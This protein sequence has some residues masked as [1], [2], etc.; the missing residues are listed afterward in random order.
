MHNG[1]IKVMDARTGRLKR[2]ETPRGKPMA[3]MEKDRLVLTEVGRQMGYKV[4]NKELVKT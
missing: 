1:L 2:W 4:T 3:V